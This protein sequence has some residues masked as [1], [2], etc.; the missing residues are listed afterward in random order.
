MRTVK[1]KILENPALKYFNSYGFA[2]LSRSL[3]ELCHSV[4]P[5]AYFNFSNSFSAVDK[6]VPLVHK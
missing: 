3:G 6:I 5:S 1:M 2:D 4:D